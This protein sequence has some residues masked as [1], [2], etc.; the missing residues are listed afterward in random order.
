LF[1]DVGGVALAKSVLL[2]NTFE[3]LT[4]I[5][6]SKKARKIIELLVATYSVTRK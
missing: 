6:K 5:A 4:T 2:R 3:E 1:D